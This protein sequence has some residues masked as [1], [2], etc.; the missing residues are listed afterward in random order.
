[1]PPDMREIQ[2]VPVKLSIE[3]KRARHETGCVFYSY[4]VR[5]RESK[6][7]IPNA[8]HAVD[9][10]ALTLVLRKRTRSRIMDDKRNSGMSR[11]RK[12]FS[13]MN[14]MQYVWIVT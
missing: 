2:H 9:Q 4:R 14:M 12:C 7:V 11:L 1:M 3:W 6:A 8:S 5:Q 13:E 10:W